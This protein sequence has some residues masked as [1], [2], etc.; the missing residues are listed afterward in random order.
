MHLGISKAL[1]SPSHM[2]K[3]QAIGKVPASAGP[4]H[5][6]LSTDAPEPLNLIPGENSM[7]WESVFQEPRD[8]PPA[9]AYTWSSYSRA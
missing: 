5:Q 3:T 6:K 4:Y 9:T 7:V 8:S 2:L 1:L